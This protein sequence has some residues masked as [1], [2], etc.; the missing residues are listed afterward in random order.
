MK[1]TIACLSLALAVPS[2]A[3]ATEF[4]TPGAIGMGGAGVAR[5]NGALTAYWNP[6]GGAFKTSP[7]AMSVGI[8]A[9]I[10][11]SDGLAENV[12]RFSSIN[13]DSV[14]NFNP[15]TAT[16]GNVSELVKT[17]SILDDISARNGSLSVNGFVPLG[18]ASKRFSFGLYGS[19][20]GYVQPL[21]DMHYVMPLNDVNA[22][23]AISLTDLSDAVARTA[24]VY[25]PTEYFSAA[26][27][28]DITNQLNASINDLAK[29]QQLT[30]AIENELMN[31]GIP[32][33]M[34][35]T[36]VVNTLI[37]TLNGG[38]T[39]NTLDM[40][41]TSVM[42]KAIQ[43][44]EAPLS[45]GH[46]VDLGKMGQLGLGVTAKLISGTVYQNQVLLVNRDTDNLTSADL[47]NDITKNK[48]TS[49]SFGIDL[50]ALYKYRN[51]LSVG[52]VGKNLNSPKF[53]AP[54]YFTPVYN[55]AN[56]RVE[57][58]QRVTGGTVELQPQVRAGIAFEPAGW[59]NFAADL[60][61]RENDTLSPGSIIG[62]SYKSRNIGGGCEFRP[63][64]WLK[65]RAGAYRNLAS[66]R[67]QVLT[68]G[69]KLFLLDVDGAFATDTFVV[70][71]NTLPQEVQ[72]NAGMSF[73][74]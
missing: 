55:P 64:S 19:M 1:K 48:K 29:S 51:W 54:D 36:S 11:G 16:S 70:D 5:N 17:L 39:N 60:D 34:V 46:P 57:L 72:I 59:L 53:D 3:S 45:Y 32:A 42:T 40:N 35:Y 12:D 24:V 74:F 30:L 62:S 69:F 10:S 21:T 61:L 65:V 27:R 6:A 4:Q 8:G 25:A 28:T 22:A 26:Q 73:S 47:V 7:F 50:G 67:K 14:K 71:G 23:T 31:S 37:P 66:T 52:I 2:L 68:A 33:S 58:S 56:G 9:G 15:N 13:F 43:Y 49:S 18:F 41:T 63:A 20:E 38:S 44:I